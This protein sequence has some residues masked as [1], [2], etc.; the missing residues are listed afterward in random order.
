MFKEI[1]DRR[2]VSLRKQFEKPLSVDEI[3]GAG[4]KQEYII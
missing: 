2:T 1:S 3:F 4:I